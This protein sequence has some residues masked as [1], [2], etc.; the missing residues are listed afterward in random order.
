MNL[1]LR[2]PWFF[3]I[4][5]L[6]FLLGTAPLL[7]KDTTASRLEKL[8]DHL[9]MLVPGSGLQEQSARI[10]AKRQLQELFTRLEDQRIRRKSSSK[11]IGLIE[12]EIRLTFLRSATRFAH[13]SALFK[14][15]EYDQSTAT[16]L[17]AL[18]FEYFGIPYRIQLEEW[19]MRLVAD[20]DGKPQQ[21][22]V[23]RKSRSRQTTNAFRQLYLELL[24]AVALVPHEEWQQPADQLFQS[25][26]FGE[27][28]HQLS[29]SELASFLLYKQA[30]AAYQRAAYVESL[31][32][33]SQAHQ[34]ADR[35]L[36]TVLR[37][38]VWLQL[39]NEEPTSQESLYYLWKIWE[40]SPGEPWQSELLHRFG[41][42]AAGQ[43][44][45][46]RGDTVIDSLYRHFHTQFAGY[47]SA[48]RQLRELYLLKMARFYAKHGQA[49]P[50]MDYMDS[51]H[52]LRPG[53]P[54]VQNVLAG[55]L[56]WSL[57]AERDFNQ[58]LEKTQYYQQRYAF[59][60]TNPLFLDQTL[61][62]QA[63]RIRYYYDRG[64][65]D[66]GAFYLREFET[67]LARAPT[68]PRRVAW[69]T[70]AYLAPSNYYFRQGDYFLAYQYIDK[71]QRLAPDDAFLQH[72]KELL[73]NYYMR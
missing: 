27:S 50:V 54:E 14:D 37:R 36:Y 18:T 22:K 64:E 3:F 56:V 70:T 59:L 32:W 10:Y 1:A 26:Y 45:P 39:A 24:Q 52:Q 44:D 71:A 9:A 65:A 7:A 49:A 17:Y 41:K 4:S 34:L 72:R 35:P 58:G 43:A 55:M 69:I 31:D 21:I 47:P 15:Q 6:I 66:R 60:A 5:L 19:E 28:S 33:L 38:A 62:Y 48:R 2:T 11:A 61:F 25:H 20:P 46:R 73:G 30:L 13:F 42:V 23:F 51:L 16:A 63:E 29:L 40:D 67:L 53:D 12:N 8:D 57:T 68:A